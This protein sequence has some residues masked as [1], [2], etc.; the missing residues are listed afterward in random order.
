MKIVSFNLN[1][2]R[3]I[4]T[5]NKSGTKITSGETVLETLIKEENP[6]ILCFQEIRCS[7][8]VNLKAIDFE[9]YG[10]KNIT[11][12]CALRKGY[13]GTA[14]F[15]K[16]K[17]FNIKLG[18]SNENNEINNEGRIITF[19]FEKFLL[20]T[21]Y[22]P[23]A[24]PD[25]SRLDFRVNIWEKTIRDYIENIKKNLKNKNI[26][27]CGDLN[28]AHNPIDVHNPTS[29]KGSHGFTIEERNAFQK[30]LDDYKLIDTFRYL[31]PN[32]KKYT[33]F[34][35]FA[36]SRERNKGWRIDYFLVS[37]NLEKKVVK[38]DI[39]GDY[40]GSD[41]IPIILEVII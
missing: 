21:V 14:I 28:V 12:N 41:H 9:K 1:G 19:E 6:D 5:K 29:A 4:L 32:E 33:W 11:L 22:V 36:K 7:D 20:I 25:L 2:I 15:S 17:P 39:L 26:I 40:Y 13:S 37:K 10:F 23:N 8:N 30:L 27:L 24:K 3:S 16:I 31:H 34:S 35:P 18:I 38:A